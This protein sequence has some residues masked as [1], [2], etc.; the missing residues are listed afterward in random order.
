MDLVDACFAG[1]AAQAELLR[2]G[3]LS[4]RELVDATLR[5]I[6]RHDRELNA[7]RL[8]FAEQALLE[9]AEAD[10][11]RAH[12][13]DAPLLGVPIAV[14]EDMAIAGLPTTTGTY[15]VDRTEPADSEVVRR[16]RAAGAVI[17]GRTRMPELG[18]WPYTESAFAGATR[19]P[20]SA[21][22][23]SGGS[24]GGSA[25]AV[26]AGLAGAA[27][28]SD[29]A[30][31]IRI[32]AASTGV[33]GLK[34]QRGRVSLHPN[35]EQW[36]GMVVAGPLSRHVRDW[37]LVADQIRGSL[38]SD[39]VAAIPPRTSFVEA[40]ATPP[41]KLRVAVSLKP[42]VAGAPVDPRVRAAVLGMAELLRELG[43]E[44]IERDPTLLD[45]TTQLALAPRY[46]SSA[47]ESVAALDRPEAVERR[48]KQVAAMGRAVPRW[49]VVRSRRFGERFSQVANQI[50]DHA[51]VLLTPTLTRPPIRVGEWQG[52][53]TLTT[54]LAANR[55]TAFLP[56]WNIAGNPA[57]S[58]PA[59][60][61]PE[62]LPLAVQLVGRPHDECTL[63]SLSSQIEQ[64]RPWADLRPPGF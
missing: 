11:R 18:L 13:E 44:V 14:K 2:A 34:P 47:A 35:G 39:P 57:A 10:E 28:G 62:G 27:I 4:S 17:V 6:E 46:L 56:Q 23:T 29:G 5:R 1:A 30:G 19:N 38:P 41:G 51:D 7:Y 15:A 63:L 31:S 52:R 59:G 25:S 12:G 32:P 50:F 9:A 48:T 21:E 58:V 49:L 64:A 54:L 24:S 55:Y 43:H 37:A 33:Y 60:F 36:T 45:P 16:L 26:C 53:S 61:T 22:H 40:A 20:W 3:E 42:W 8:V